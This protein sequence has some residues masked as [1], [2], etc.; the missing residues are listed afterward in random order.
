MIGRVLFDTFFVSHDWPLSSSVAI[1][2]L[3]LVVVP[4]ALL[5]RNR[6][7]EIEGSP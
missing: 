1:I 7:K 2:L 3:V 6:Q 5:Q 4:I